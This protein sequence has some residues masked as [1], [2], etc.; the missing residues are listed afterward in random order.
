M[1]LSLPSEHL[2][3]DALAPHSCN[4]C[5]RIEVC[6][7]DGSVSQNFDFTFDKVNKAANSGC[8]L[9]QRLIKSLFKLTITP[10]W[11]PDSP[12]LWVRI[13]FNSDSEDPPCM[14]ISWFEGGQ[15]ISPEEDPD[16]LW[17][18]PWRV[19]LYVY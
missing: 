9:F 18:L 16:E 1:D 15:L 19:F 10:Y 6:C 12:S 4:H 13:C 7:Y 14:D 17:I 8:C 11:Q 2:E 3:L 5:R